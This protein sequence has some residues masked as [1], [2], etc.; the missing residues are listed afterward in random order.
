MVKRFF[1]PASKELIVTIAEDI[2]QRYHQRREMAKSREELQ[3]QLVEFKTDLKA[4]QKKLAKAV[5]DKNDSAVINY[6]M[7]V[8]GL[9][10]SIQEL[11]EQLRNM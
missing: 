10:N 5:K 8:A 3:R 6:S 7:S 1:T 11:E 9:K 4:H 2:F